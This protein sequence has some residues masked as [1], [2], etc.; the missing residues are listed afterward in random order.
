MQVSVETSEGL[1]R[2]LIVSVPSEKVEEEVDLRLRDLARKA[3]VPGFRPGKVPMNI[4][5]K[6]YSDSVREDVARE[7]V[8]STLYEALT[9]NNLM[10][11]G[12]PSVEPEEITAGKDFKYT[13]TFEIFP[14]IE[15][16]E[17]D[18]VE[19][20]QTKAT[21]SETD[22]DN[23]LRK[24]QEQ[25][26]TWEKVSRTTQDGDKVSIDFKGFINNE[27][28]AG[29]EAKNH[30]LVLGSNSMIPG[31]E[32]AL[33]GKEIGTP[34]DITVTFP[35]DYNHNDLAG[36]E[37]L[38]NI[39]ISEVSEG[40]LPE[41]DDAFAEKFNI[42]DG[43]VDALKKDIKENMTRELERRVSSMN[44]ERIFDVLMQANPFDI[45]NALI[46]QE[47]EH[48]KHE[49]YHRLFGNE[50]HENEKI[51]DFP[52][53]LFE[54]QAK[55]RVHL[56]LLFSEYVKHHS[57]SPDKARVDGMIEK[58]ANAYEDPEELKEW[59]QGNKERLAE[60]EALVMEEM[61]AE[62]AGET[63]KIVV[64]EKQYDDVMNPKK[65][66]GEEA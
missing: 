31:F 9:T 26:K 42:K 2:K 44:R 58:F 41:L 10:P 17:I 14:S 33:I 30:E 47:I 36:K 20:E 29:G 27:A 40:Q 13:A 46:E 6:R 51:P 39:T 28:F 3:K 54:E 32:T 65:D 7:M 59:Y 16:K 23:M 24:L 38:F 56:G 60:I 45:P 48:L 55:R 8:Q 50:H 37:A 35:E 15:I 11:A 61:V 21:V 52:R 18:H 34:F 19:I 64:I 1:E 5:R 22:L 57:I 66:E 63:A 53:E 12:S 62:K 49:M 4:V 25:N 43:G